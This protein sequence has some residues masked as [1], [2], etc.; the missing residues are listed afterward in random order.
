MIPASAHLRNPAPR[1]LPLAPL[2]KIDSRSVGI[3]P[4]DPD[5]EG[6]IERLAYILAKPGLGAFEAVYNRIDSLLADADALRQ[7]ALK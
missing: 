4:L 3:P 2:A 1:A 6:F 7:P 5:L